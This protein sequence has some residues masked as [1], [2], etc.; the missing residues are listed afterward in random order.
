MKKIWNCT[1]MYVVTFS[2]LSA[3]LSDE[4]VLGASNIIG[5][6]GPKAITS[7]LRLNSGI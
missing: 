7:R 5:H 2:I 6:R 4:L 1:N 3:I